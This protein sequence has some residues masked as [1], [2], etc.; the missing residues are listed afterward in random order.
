[1]SGKSIIQKI[2][3]EKNVRESKFKLEEL[4][5]LLERGSQ[6]EQEVACHF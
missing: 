6:M 2:T 3:K 1:M 5:P 4:C